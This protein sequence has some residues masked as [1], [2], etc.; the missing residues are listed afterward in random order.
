MLKVIKISKALKAGLPEELKITNI[1]KEHLDKDTLTIELMGR[2]IS[3]VIQG[4]RK[5]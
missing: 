3:L 1:H 2:S 4:H 5:A